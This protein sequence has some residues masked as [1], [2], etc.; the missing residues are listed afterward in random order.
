M[1]LSL[2]LSLLC[3]WWRCYCECLC[4]YLRIKD[5]RLIFPLPFYYHRWDNLTDVEQLFNYWKIFLKLYPSLCFFFIYCKSLYV[6]AL[7]H[8]PTAPKCVAEPRL[9]TTES[10]EIFLS[11]SSSRSFNWLRRSSPYHSKKVVSEEA[12]DKHIRYAAGASSLNTPGNSIKFFTFVKF[13]EM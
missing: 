4:Q 5:A 7:W 9:G 12:A 2:L 10:N 11:F 1:L 3:W 13:S 6:I 8:Y